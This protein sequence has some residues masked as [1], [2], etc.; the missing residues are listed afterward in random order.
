MAITSRGQL[1]VA[2]ACA[3]AG[4]LLLTAFSSSDVAG[5]M[6]QP[7]EGEVIAIFSKERGRFLEVSPHDGRLRATATAPTNMTALFRVRSQRSNPRPCQ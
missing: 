2:C 5:P 4:L 1:L 6:L 7:K 3:C